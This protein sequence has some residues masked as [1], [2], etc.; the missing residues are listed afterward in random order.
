MS[1]NATFNFDFDERPAREQLH[2]LTAKLWSFRS[3]CKRLKCGAVITTSD[4]RKIVG[5]GYNGPAKGLPDDNCLDIMGQCG[6]LHAEDNAINSLRGDGGEV[7]FCSTYPCFM[8]AQRIINAGIKKVYYLI[9]YREPHQVFEHCS[10]PA[11]KL[12]MTL[13]E[14]FYQVE[15]PLKPEWKPMSI[16]EVIGNDPTYPLGHE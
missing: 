6:C 7:I 5:F 8:C 3:T 2:L 10:I 12:E 11:V 4:Y 16:D 1:I 9:S 13:N 15:R 14:E